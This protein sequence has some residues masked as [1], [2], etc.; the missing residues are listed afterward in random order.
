MDRQVGCKLQ[1]IFSF[2]FFLFLYLLWQ[3]RRNT[4]KFLEAYKNSLKRKCLTKPSIVDFIVGDLVGCMMIHNFF[5][6]QII[7][8]LLRY[9]TYLGTNMGRSF[10]LVHTDKKN[11]QTINISAMFS[12]SVP[13]LNRLCVVAWNFKECDFGSKQQN[14]LLLFKS[15]YYK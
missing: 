9:I 7:Y 6:F 15:I 4:S 5:Q 13:I 2:F 14:H 11:D 12:E 1:C 10:W 8:I 3:W